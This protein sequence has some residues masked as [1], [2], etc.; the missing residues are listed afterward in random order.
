VIAAMGVMSFVSIPHLV[1]VDRA[2]EMD[3]A[4]IAGL[5]GIG[6]G[7]VIT[8]DSHAALGGG[9]HLRNLNEKRPRPEPGSLVVPET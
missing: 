3:E 9:T 1:I 4:I 8:R 6:A 2:D 5:C 7:L